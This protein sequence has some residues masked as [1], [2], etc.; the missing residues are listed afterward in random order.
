M[1]RQRKPMWNKDRCKANKHGRMEEEE[2]KQKIDSTNANFL[3]TNIIFKKK[4]IFPEEETLFFLPFFSIYFNFFKI[5]GMLYLN[6]IESLMC[7]FPSTSSSSLLFVRLDAI[8][9]LE[10]VLCMPWYRHHK[11]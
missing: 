10:I 4:K 2:A 5:V 9:P 6:Y 7:F 11:F 3:R 1:E 8:F